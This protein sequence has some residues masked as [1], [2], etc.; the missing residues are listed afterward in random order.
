M[1]QNDHIDIVL[2]YVLDK[3]LEDFAQN[4][5]ENHVYFHTLAAFEGEEEAR[6]YLYQAIKDLSN[7]D[8]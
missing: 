6:K 1:N 4:P 2:N 5:S 3:E 8:V 7:V